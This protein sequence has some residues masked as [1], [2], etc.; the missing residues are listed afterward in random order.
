MGTRMLRTNI[1]QPPTQEDTFINPRYDALEELTKNEEMF[2]ELRKC[3]YLVN[4]TDGWS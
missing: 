3:M 1:L 2:W 4:F